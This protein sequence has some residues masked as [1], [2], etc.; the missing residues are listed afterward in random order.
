M[1]DVDAGTVHDVF[2][3]HIPSGG[4][5]L[6]IW[7]LPADGRWQRGAVVEAWYFAD[8]PATAWAE[9]YR[10]LAATGVPPAQALPRDLWRW[11]IDLDRVALLDDEQ[12][13]A[14]VGLGPPL[15]TQAQWPAC[16]DIGE[17]LRGEGYDA[18]LVSS[19]ARPGCRNL[20]VFRTADRVVGCKPEPPPTTVV[21]PPPVPRGMRT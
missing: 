14:R 11:R 15:P 6:Q 13:L 7:P 12:R 2:V 20:V 18:L 19:A 3:R 1:L 5:P 16:Q 4:D 9:W 10:A 21:D 17:V 8:E